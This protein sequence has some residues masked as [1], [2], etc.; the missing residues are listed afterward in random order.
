MLLGKAGPVPLKHSYAIQMTTAV[1][2]TAKNVFSARHC[3]LL[4]SR[5]QQ[6]QGVAARDQQRHLQNARLILSPDVSQRWERRG[7]LWDR[8]KWR[9]PAQFLPFLSFLLILLLLVILLFLLFLLGLTRRQRFLKLSPEVRPFE[10]RRLHRP[11]LQEPS[12]AA[13]KT[14]T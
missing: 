1:K 9:A 11:R 8:R 14:T 2:M 10:A 6:G 12:V 13:P 3:G 4:Q 7:W 5:C